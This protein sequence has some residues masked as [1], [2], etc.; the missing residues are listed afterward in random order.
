[1]EGDD[2]EEQGQPRL[3]HGGGV[4]RDDLPADGRHQEAC[5]W[6]SVGVFGGR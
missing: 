6:M 4:G 2:R 5:G 1:M 3:G